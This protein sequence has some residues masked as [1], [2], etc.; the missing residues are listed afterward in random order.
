MAERRPLTE[1]LKPPVPAVDPV[2]EK[3]FVYGPDPEPKTSASRETHGNQSRRT[4]PLRD[5]LSTRMRR[6]YAAAL[7]RAALQRRLD[8]VHPNTVTEILEEAI[9]PGLR[10]HGYLT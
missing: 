6:D 2:K 9:E 5:P 4:I 1:G 3:D 7:M 8:G 10:K